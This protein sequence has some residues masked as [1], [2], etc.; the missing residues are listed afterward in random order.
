MCSRF[1]TRKGIGF[2]NI[3]GEAKAVKPEAIDASKNT[4]LPKFLEEYSI[5]DIYSADK[6]GLFYKLQ[7]S[8]C[9]VLKD[10]DGSGGKCSKS[11]IAVTPMANMSGTHKLK[12]LVINNSWKTHI[13]SQKR[14]NVRQLLVEFHSNKKAWMTSNVFTSR[15]GSSLGKRGVW[16]L[17]GAIALLILKSTAP[18]SRGGIYALQ[19]LEHS[20]EPG[21]PDPLGPP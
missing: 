16:P 21:G 9:L 10:E 20:L 13:F 1:K 11:R 17:S 3:K 5:N 14:T 18:L 15:T 8:K 6:N 19:S 4:L 12:P 7:P 2:C